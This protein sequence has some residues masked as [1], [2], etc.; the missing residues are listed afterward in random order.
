MKKVPFQTIEQVEAY[1]D[2]EEIP[3]LICGKAFKGL[4]T[5]INRLHQIS[6]DEYKFKFGIPR[7]YGLAG[8]SFRA[9]SARMMIE[10][11][12]KGLLPAAP[13]EEHIAMLHRIKKKPAFVPCI[14]AL[15]QKNGNEREAQRWSV[16]DYDE[17]ITRMAT[18]RTMWEV[19][20]DKDLMGLVRFKK[21]CK[22]NT[23]FEDRLIEVIDNLSFLI[24]IRGRHPGPSLKGLVAL[25]HD[26]YQLGWVDIA[27]AL[28]LQS[29][30]VRN[31]Y[32]KYVT[33]ERAK[34]Q[35]EVI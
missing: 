26:E 32:C 31:I 7:K 19:G 16:S 2:Q 35:L 34:K 27:W 14:R 3:C 28:G 18:G 30:M 5:H 24:Q 1:L 33:R 9:N 22:S 6:V 13:T 12:E 20:R 29:H 4:H 15:H 11:R 21:W 25:L 10:K 17:Y 23:E 8:K